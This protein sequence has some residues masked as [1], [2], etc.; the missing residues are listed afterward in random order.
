MGRKF[1]HICTGFNLDFNGGITNYVRCLAKQ[2]ADNGN[3]VYVLCDS[4]NP[5]GY[6]IIE[7]K[8]KVRTWGFYK[9]KDKKS[10][11]DL[12]QLIK[13]YSFDLIHIHMMLNVDQDLYKIL[14]DEKYV[15]SLHDYYFICPRIQMVAPNKTRCCAANTEN[16]QK[17]FSIL[18]KNWFL[19]GG[20]RR[21]FGESFAYK[22][23][24]KSKKVYNRWFNR[25][26]QLLENARMLFPVSTRVEEIYK[27]SGVNNEYHTLHIGNISAERFKDT[28]TKPK[29]EKI[30]LVLLSNV[31]RIKGGPLFFDIL[32]KVD[33][34]T[35]R[36]H[37]YG[38]CDN[39]TKK[40]FK[41]LNIEYHGEYKQVDLPEILFKM[42]M[43]VMTPIWEDNGPQVI[44]EMLNNNLPVFATKMGGI[45]DFVNSENG[46]IFNPFDE[47]EI[48]RAV[49]FLNN[50]NFEKINE[51]RANIKRTLTPYEHY[52]ELTRFYERI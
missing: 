32:R 18:E 34:P 17:C 23:P 9:R 11:N 29:N 27:T 15:V 26:K 33:N 43:G 20:L 8:S 48:N 47:I 12:K 7:F 6:E 19:S 14:E 44:M 39:K 21:L 51:L 31:N 24:F 25:N 52:E 49:E 50:L 5:N 3:K 36:V 40:I 2:Q 35:L 38:R 45:T 28:K 16:C 41:E 10:L 4:G 30:N 1:L 37:F 42:D 46:F 13:L 22:F